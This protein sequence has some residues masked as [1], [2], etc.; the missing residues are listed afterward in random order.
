MA[1]L[2]KLWL[3][4]LLTVI[5]T[6]IFAYGQTVRFG[7][8]AVGGANAS[9]LSYIRAY[10]VTFDPASVATIT[11]AVQTI[12][13]AATGAAIGDKV[14]VNPRAVIVAGLGLGE[15]F[16]SAADTVRCVFIN[17]T[18]GALDAASGTW[19]ILIIRNR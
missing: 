19:D 16:V 13:S 15:C 9:E 2:K 10:S 1:Y 18:A 17:P 4:L 7:T 8:L 14:I 5:L 12:T 6:A 3:P 11:T